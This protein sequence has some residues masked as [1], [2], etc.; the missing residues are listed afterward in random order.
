MDAARAA[1][2]HDTVGAVSGFAI[3]LA[4]TTAAFLWDGTG[5][6]PEFATRDARLVRE[7]VMNDPQRPLYHFTMLDGDDVVGLK[8]CVLGT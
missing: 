4:A 5:D 8:R 1:Q 6:V 2:G 7:R 3:L